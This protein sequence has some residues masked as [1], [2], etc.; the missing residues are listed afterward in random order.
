VGDLPT[1]APDRRH[2]R[3]DTLAA[4]RNGDE[5]AFG[6]LV[7]PH[8]SELRVHC[9]RMLGSLQDA[10]DVLQETLL[11]AW[12]HLDDLTDPNAVRAWLYRIA[13]NR[14]LTM[15]TASARHHLDVPLDPLI[16]SMANSSTSEAAPL[17]PFPDRLLPDTGFGVED[18]EAAIESRADVELAF[19]A[20]LQLLPPRQRAIL[21][22]RDA[23]EW[24][25]AD[26]ADLL[27]TSVAAV[28]SA[29]QRARATL[30]RERKRGR[31]SRLHDPASPAA[32]RDL[33]NRFVAAFRSADIEAFVRLLRE[34]ALLTM[35]PYPA[36]FQ[37]PSAIGRFFATVPAAGR[38][39]RLRLV[40]TRANGQPAL[41]AYGPAEGGKRHAYGIMVLTMEGEAIT[42]ITGF[43][44]AQLFG[45]FGLPATLEP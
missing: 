40:V 6:R 34:N 39:D 5:A 38:L 31:L 19:I 27:E 26:A 45:Y 15:R 9:Y 2:G 10:E 14:C 18:P 24:S 21:L 8:R 42:A 37:G 28:N 7:E 25:A 16:A 4:A 12:R 11:R 32:E 17:Q 20:V 35:P 36:G 30:A 44:G 33:V 29:L 41:A 43:L 22:L 23:L 3:E 1:P 13:T